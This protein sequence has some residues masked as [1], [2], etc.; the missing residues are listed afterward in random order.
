MP[1]FEHILEKDGLPASLH[2]EKVV[3]G[4]LLSDPEYNTH[5]F[6]MIRE[7]DF[8]VDNHRQF[9]RAM[10]NLKLERNINADFASLAECFTRQELDALGGRATIIALTEGLPRHLNVEN[11]ARVLRDKSLLRQVL[12][13]CQD[14]MLRAARQS[15]D[16]RVILNDLA[17]RVNEI[18]AEGASEE[19]SME[20]QSAQAWEKL[21]KTA[22]GEMLAFIP[23]GVESLDLSHGGYAIGEFTVI[24][25]R[26]NVGKSTLL[27]QGIVS[28]CTAGNFVHLFTPEMSSDQVHFC[29]WAFMGEIPFHKVR[30]PDRLTAADWRMIRIARDTVK[31]WPLYV[32]QTAQISAPEL[33]NRA[34]AKKRK[35]DTKLVGL[36][37]LQKL[38]YRGRS[39]ER[40]VEVTDSAVALAGFAKTEQVAL[41][42]ISSITEPGEKNRNRPPTIQDFRQSGDIQYEANTAILLHREFEDES[43]QLQPKTSLIVG[44]GRS[45]PT[46]SRTLYFM[47]AQQQFVSEETYM[48][49]LGR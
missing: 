3:L 1:A 49:S 13:S 18:G 24:G 11:Y 34:R 44:K 42:A 9:F 5:V 38:R 29:L 47:G 22:S 41:V 10:Q 30:H 31:D 20:D 32:D 37:Y 28:N 21:E 46:G 12:T 27:R 36:D 14:V 15:E 7:E 8:S 23:T 26:P 6:A 40:H 48:R 43:Q 17:Q 39:Q 16:P 33:I 19:Q 2:M 35:C 25:A 45:D 4:A